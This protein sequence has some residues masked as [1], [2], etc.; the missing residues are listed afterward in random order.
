MGPG[1][2][3][4]LLTTGLIRADAE[5]RIRWANRAAADLLACS[6][7]KLPNRCLAEF[8][9]VLADWCARSRRQ[10]QTL[11][12]LE[13]TL[14]PGLATVDV[15]IQRVGAESLIELS[16][17]AERLRQR[18]RLERADRQQA[19]A[20]LS[21]GLA[22]EL[23][24]P[25]AG[26]RGAAQLIE[27]ADDP[28]AIRRHAGLI[29]REVDR[30]T[31]LIERFAG[32][33]TTVKAGP[34]NLHQIL[35]EVAE[36]VRAERHGD[37]MVETGF[38]PSIPL[39]AGDSG[40]LHQLF[41]NLMRNSVQAGASRIGL[42]TRIE[43]HSAVVEEPARHAVRIDI[44]DD[45]DGVPPALRETLFLPLVTGRA[46]GSG[47]GLALVQQIA[48]QHGGLVEFEA[49]ERGSRFRVRL[50]LILAGRAA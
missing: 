13:T 48:R 6:D 18:E 9:P 31:A 41:L 32:S 24:N 36:L 45:G 2:D 12:A 27:K 7:R 34:V 11:T 42:Q 43:H 8:S 1:V 46:Q 15:R 10:D 4:E 44:E 47:F 28:A 16:P 29:Q 22:H 14:A 19:L 17:V 20:G 37:L 30:I 50:P 21:R 49:L 5:D 40:R 35:S 25:L 26:V 23:R 3:A 39:L 38:D 33:D